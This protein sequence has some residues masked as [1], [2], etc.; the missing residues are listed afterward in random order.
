MTST[1][2]TPT[3][4]GLTLNSLLCSVLSLSVFESSVT[5]LYALPFALYVVT[6][7]MRDSR[8]LV[9]GVTPLCVWFWISTLFLVAHRNL[10]MFASVAIAF[11]V[12]VHYSRLRIVWGTPFDD[13][14]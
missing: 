5:G 2:P 9:V 13:D 14:E 8:C 3:V 6:L 10:L 4:H 12:A 1:R 11:L 7:G